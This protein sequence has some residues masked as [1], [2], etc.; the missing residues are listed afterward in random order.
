MK[1]LIMSVR[2]LGLVSIV[3]GALVWAEHENLLAA[4]IGV[5]FLV[6]LAVFALAVAALL[7]K[8]I[9]P[10]IVGVIISLLLPVIG[11]LQLPATFHTL[12]LIQVL[13]IMVAL[14]IIGLAERLYSATRVSR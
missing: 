9:V 13:H 1:A 6:A 3:L 4:H 7:K 10:G 11:F 12:R 5:G 8:A 14:S 2:V